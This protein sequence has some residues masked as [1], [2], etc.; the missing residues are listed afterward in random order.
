LFGT[1]TAH[2]AALFTVWGDAQGRRFLEALRAND[3]HIASSN[4]ESADRVAA[5]TYA[6]GLVDSDDVYSR[7]RQG[8]PVEGVHPDQG[9]NELG[10]LI[11]PNAVLLI[12]G[13]PHSAAGRK[14]I[15][16]L[17]SPATERKLADSDAAQIPLHAGVETPPDVP[18][19][20]TLKVMNVD[21][22]RVAA[23]MQT[24]QPLLRDWAGQ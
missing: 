21:Y 12:K 23:E 9:E 22:A 4:G 1:T 16:Y 18:R 14:L 6:F 2:V 3:V 10:C 24:I 15:D 5:G 11:V 17:L 7:R 13:G 20:E 8:Q 19:I